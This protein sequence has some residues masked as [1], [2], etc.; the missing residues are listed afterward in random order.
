MMEKYNAYDSNGKAIRSKLAVHPGEILEDEIIARGLKKNFFAKQIHIKP[1]NLSEILAG[2][3]NISAALAYRI[4]QILE[5][6]AE[7]WLRSQIRYDITAVR[8]THAD[9]ALTNN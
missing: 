4:E 2:K 8:N 1:S 3:R 5:I 7:F 9:P 6:D